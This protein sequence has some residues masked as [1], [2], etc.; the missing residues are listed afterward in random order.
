MRKRK[1]PYDRKWH[2]LIASFYLQLGRR[3]TVKTSQ[4]QN[5]QSVCMLCC[6]D[7]M[8]YNKN[9]DPRQTWPNNG[10]SSGGVSVFPFWEGP[11]GCTDYIR[12]RSPWGGCQI[13][14]HK[15][16]HYQTLLISIVLFD[17]IF[18]LS[19]GFPVHWNSFAIVLFG[20]TGFKLRTSHFARQVSNA[21]CPQPSHHLGIL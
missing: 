17:P 18:F 2:N 15:V 12:E 9:W 21:P 5:I 10:S 1:D 13:L 11:E 19:W 7:G 20:S 8:Y 4:L 16:S 14:S 3:G 6:H